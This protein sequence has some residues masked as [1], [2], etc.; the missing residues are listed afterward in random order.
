[1]G[2][3][4][5]GEECGA[6]RHIASR[7]TPWCLD[8][9]MFLGRTNLSACSQEAT[10]PDLLFSNTSLISELTLEFRRLRCFPN[11]SSVGMPSVLA[12]ASLY[13]QIFPMWSQ[14]MIPVL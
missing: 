13:Q 3:I 6:D 8:G 14:E 5:S 11:I 4:P 7:P 12:A 2:T 9:K 10:I 1:M